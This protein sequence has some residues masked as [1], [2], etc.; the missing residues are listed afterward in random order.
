MNKQDQ[1]KAYKVM[2][3]GLMLTHNRMP[4]AMPV[5]ETMTGQNK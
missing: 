3:W 1:V 4:V 2:L 5:S